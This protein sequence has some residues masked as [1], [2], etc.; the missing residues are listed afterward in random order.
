MQIKTVSVSF[1]S[2][3]NLGNYS[4]IK[5]AATVEAEL[6]GQ[7][8]EE[9][10]QQL[11]DAARRQVAYVV[12]AMIEREISEWDIEHF[13]TDPARFEARVQSRLQGLPM[14]GW[15][16]TVAPDVL[17]EIELPKPLPMPEP[18]REEDG[19]P[20]EGEEFNET[21]VL[22][23]AEDDYEAAPDESDHYDDEDDDFE[24]EDD[25]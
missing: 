2:T 15:M 1:E 20:Y 3:V 25:F 16:K 7:T 19:E 18:E 17:A 11:M 8:I 13:P 9:A 24:D 23:D 12:K 6:N 4:N 10:T 21:N 5:P 14:F 22:K